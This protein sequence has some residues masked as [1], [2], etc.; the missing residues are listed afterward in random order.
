[1]TDILKL[2]WQEI[3]KLSLDEAKE[4]Q[5]VARDILL[6]TDVGDEIGLIHSLLGKLNNH[7]KLINKANH[8]SKKSLAS[9]LKEQKQARNAMKIEMEKIKS[10]RAAMIEEINYLKSKISRL[11]KQNTFNSRFKR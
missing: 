8:A 10:E 6:A 1:M 2:D 7:I 5:L 11:E 3:K 4:M 9:R